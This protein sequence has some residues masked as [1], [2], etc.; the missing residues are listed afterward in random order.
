M[1]ACINRQLRLLGASKGAYL[2][3]YAL[4]LPV[5]IGFGIASLDISRFLHVRE[6]VRTAAHTSTRCLYTTDGNCVSGANN[7]DPDRMYSWYE[8]NVVYTQ[9]TY[10]H[11][12]SALRQYLSHLEFRPTAQVLA[13]ITYDIGGEFISERNGGAI[14]EGQ[15]PYWERISTFPNINTDDDA[16]TARNRSVGGANIDMSFNASATASNGRN[17]TFSTPSFIINRPS[18]LAELS[19]PYTYKDCYRSFGSPQPYKQSKKQLFF[20]LA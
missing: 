1:I 9:A 10:R 19:N 8:A 5:I 3:E 7:K 11:V 4:V 16:N 17:S 13:S 20:Q 2:L 6:A 14:Y 12:G 18:A 15:L